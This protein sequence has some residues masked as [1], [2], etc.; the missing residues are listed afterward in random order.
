MTDVIIS[1]WV[2]ASALGALCLALLFFG[3]LPSLLIARRVG[4]V[5]GEINGLRADAT[6]FKAALVSDLRA[7]LGDVADRQIEAADRHKT[8]LGEQI[9]A[10]LREPLDGVAKG[11][12]EFGSAQSASISHGLEQQVSKFAEKLDALLGGQVAQA[13]ELQVKTCN[14]LE[15]T[16]G[17]FQNMA[18]SFEASAERSTLAMAK[19]LRAELSKTQAEAEANL[20]EAVGRLATQLAGAMNSVQ[21]QSLQSGRT[22]L[23]QQKRIADQA[24]DAI[25]SLAT[26]VRAQSAAI[27]QTA[28]SMRSVG[29]DTTKAVERII[30]GMTGLISGAAQEIMRSGKGFT[31]IFEKSAALNRDLTQTASALSGSSKDLGSLVD[32]YRGA[33]EALDTMVGLMREAVETARNDSS[34][35]SDVIDRIEAAARRLVAAQSQADE[36]LANLSG[37]LGEAHQA[38]GTQMIDTVRQFHDHL[39]QASTAQPDAEDVHHQHADLDRM[40]SDW[41]Q[42]APRMRRRR[43]RVARSDGDQLVATRPA[44]PGSGRK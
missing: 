2:I 30:E 1:Q 16:V 35:A 6:E 31:E 4:S 7:I 41:V 22:A 27:E 26:E 18:K 11:L 14:S 10:A 13:H 44:L 9:T 8:A 20:R 21:E 12:Q 34:L 42:T 19:Q 43:A 33:R 3:L 17:A 37:V 29:A 23:E 39:L 25:E 36:Q 15:S 40:I 32:D 5:K 28:E 38:F 24:Q